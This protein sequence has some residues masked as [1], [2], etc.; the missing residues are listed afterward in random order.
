MNCVYLLI[1]KLEKGEA[2]HNEAG[3]K[4]LVLEKT[5][6]EPMVMLVIKVL[7]YYTVPERKVCMPLYC[8]LSAESYN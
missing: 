6:G 5:T 1:N 8:Y 4:V 7:W 2:D 3:L